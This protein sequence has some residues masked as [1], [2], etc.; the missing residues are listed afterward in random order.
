MKKFVLCLVVF[1]AFIFHSEF[2]R[3]PSNAQIRGS[4]TRESKAE[5][6]GLTS[7]LREKAL[8]S[9]NV[10]VIV[11]LAAPFIPE[12]KASK[13]SRD[14]Q[15]LQIKEKQSLFRS[16][17]TGLSA[18]TIKNFKFIPFVAIE[19]DADSLDRMLSDPSI[20]NVEEDTLSAPTLAESTLLVG[21]QAAWADGYSGEGQ[22]I[23]ILDTGVD[24]T[25]S[26]LSGK[27]VS[28]ACYSS[29][30]SSSISTCP[31]GVTSST[32]SDSGLP[33]DLSVSGCTH[34][35]H[36][37]GIAAGTGTSSSGVAR[38]AH[39]IAI[40]VF[41]R[42]NASSDCGT[43]AA[44]CALSFQSDQI[45]ALERVLELS[46]TMNI[47][48][49]NLSLGSGQFTS[50]CDAQ[51]ISF[52]YAVDNLRSRGV[53]TVISSGNS[54][55]TNATSGPACVST[56]IS[57]GSV[58]DGSSGTTGDA[59]SS[60]SNSAPFLSLLA[61][62]RW[63]LSSIPGG[64]FS[65]FSGTSMAAPHVAGAMAV[66]KQ[67]KPDATVAEMVTALKTSG[68]PITDPRNNLVKP[69]I[70]I[71]DALT[72]IMNLPKHT[73][74]DFD[75]DGRADI[76]VVRPTDNKWYIDRSQ[77]GFTETS[78]GVTGDKVTPADFDGD[79]KTDIAVWRPSDGNW[80]IISSDLNT[81]RSVPWGVDGD[82]PVPADFDGDKKAD[83]AVFRP[84]D[85]TWYRILSQQGYSFVNF[86]V[87]GDKPQLGDF[88][89]DTK[90]DLAVYR[91][92]TGFWYLYMT[93]EGFRGY[94]WGI[95][96]DVPV[97][98][99]FN[100][101]GR[102]ELG[103]FRPA[104]GDWWTYEPSTFAVSRAV[105]GQTGDVP[106]PADYDGDGKCDYSVFR[107]GSGTTYVLKSSGGIFSQTFGVDGDR[108]LASAFLN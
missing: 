85:G 11:H 72:A 15:R 89:G 52:K 92:S 78:F 70:E 30:G 37:A 32:A 63:I 33:C 94:N 42:F 5:R 19:A 48:S 44:P 41:S 75:G 83:L 69:R 1:S 68:T 106:S 95:D 45:R 26:F 56:A 91:P 77:A 17:Y 58:D 84:S 28:E 6:D 24:K 87:A 76:S 61:P 21:A 104:T 53:A 23:A 7:S 96:G 88:D 64:A 80:Y 3:T 108:P 103:I 65:N 18:E 62:G 47:A 16:K 100:G 27:V 81:F 55:Y 49:V 20:L 9:G 86:G 10:R 66:L 46:T 102:T 43:S 59:V 51:R 38:D 35:T 40:K 60:F 97:P 22:N 107:P 71:D 57:V 101:D 50:N 25:H 93:T 13:Q 54:G 12:G 90:A 36:V 39:L 31:D 73:P 98:G 82:V 79:G 74:F 67:R 99:D 14:A 4:E 8:K 105:W 2:G 34:G 29:N